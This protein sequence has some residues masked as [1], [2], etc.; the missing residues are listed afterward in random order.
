MA[1]LPLFTCDF[2]SRR[3]GYNL[4]TFF[5]KSSKEGT[6]ILGKC[7]LECRN[8]PDGFYYTC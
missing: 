8:I 4:E 5:F 7:Y 1:E 2:S 3:S 6:A